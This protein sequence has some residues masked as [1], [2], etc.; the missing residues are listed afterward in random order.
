[1]SDPCS[2]PLD[3]KGLGS[4]IIPAGNTGLGP[5]PLKAPKEWECRKFR[6]SHHLAHGV[7]T[8]TPKETKGR[9]TPVAGIA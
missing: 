5:I 6:V 9:G 8:Y 7:G 2:E 4:F 3:S 1:M